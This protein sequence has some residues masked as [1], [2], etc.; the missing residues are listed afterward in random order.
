MTT[1]SAFALAQREDVEM[2]IVEAVHRTLFEQQPARQSIAALM[3]R[4]LRAEGD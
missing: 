1:Q 2:P 4:E 3:A